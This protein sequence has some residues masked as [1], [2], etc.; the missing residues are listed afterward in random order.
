MVKCIDEINWYLQKKVIITRN[1]DGIMK[2]DIGITKKMVG[3]L[4]TECHNYE[5]RIIT[6]SISMSK[7]S[8]IEDKL[9]V[10]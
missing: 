2:S 4:S 5:R 1:G 6:I 7:I 10:V 3:K 9:V 8:D